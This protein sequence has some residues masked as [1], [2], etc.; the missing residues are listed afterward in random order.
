M[1]WGPE[2][3]QVLVLQEASSRLT[4]CGLG[5]KKKSLHNATPSRCGGPRVSV[6]IAPSNAL[7]AV[8]EAPSFYYSSE[9]RSC[10]LERGSIVGQEAFLSLS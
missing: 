1:I 7:S 10:R 4:L 3:Q 8:E 6:H 2:K 9:E 5:E